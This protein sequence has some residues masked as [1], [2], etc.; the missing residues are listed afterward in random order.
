MFKIQHQVYEGTWMDTRMMVGG[1]TERAV[2]QNLA[3]ALAA[4]DEFRKVDRWTKFRVLPN[5]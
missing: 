4:I 3:S 1:R 2:F 5:V